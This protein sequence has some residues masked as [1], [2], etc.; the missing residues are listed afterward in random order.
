MPLLSICIPTYNRSSLLRES[1]AYILVA[2]K[3]HEDKIEIVISDNASTDDTQM[4]C[5][6]FQNNRRFDI[7]YYRNFENTVD[8]N[9]FIVAG[10]ARGEYIWIL[11]DDDRIEPEAIGTVLKLLESAHNLIICNHSIW[12]NNFSTLIR[13]K[14]L[15]FDR[16]AIFDD[17]NELLMHL[18]PKLGFISCLIIKREIFLS[19]PADELEPLL[20]YGFAFLYAIYRAMLNKCKA[21]LIAFPL[22]LNNGSDSCANKEWWY[23]C[24]VQGT[25]LT[26]QALQNK[27][28][29]SYAIFYAKQLVLKEY[30]LH[31]ISLRKRSGEDI[32]GLFKWM[33]PYYKTHI[34]FWFVIVPMLIT[35]KPFIW[36][37]HKTIINTRKIIKEFKHNLC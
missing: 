5:V 34:F 17:H 22:V 32:R 35:P 15:P 28:Y 4:I 19:V 6:H 23:K 14:F 3:G 37:G 13:N 20:P 12:S 7:K 9:F 18:G 10:L 1:L 33:V 25:S 8:R 26:F 24:F 36:I 30:V 21:Y 11:G 16:D 31:D 2:A 29:L 27:G